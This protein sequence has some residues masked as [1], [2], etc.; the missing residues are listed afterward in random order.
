MSLPTNRMPGDVIKA[1]DIN[2]IAEA[3]NALSDGTTDHSAL[4]NRD[5][6]D[7]HPISAITGLQ[8][9]LNGK[10]N[11][12]HT[13]GAADL[14]GVVKTVNGEAPDSSGDVAVAG[15][16]AGEFELRGTGMPN[17][18]VTATPGTYY[19]DTAG[20]NGAWRWLKT[21]GAGNTG[22]EVVHGDTGRR[23]IVSM[24]PAPWN[25]GMSSLRLHRVGSIVTVTGAPVVIPTDSGLSNIDI[26][27]LPV[28]FRA[29]GY[30]P[31][32][33]A[34]MPNHP[35]ATN[36]AISGNWLYV[37]AGGAGFSSSIAYQF[38]HSLT[39]VTG[40]PWPTVLPGVPA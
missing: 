6:A 31:A 27:A 4:S 7:Q 34:A 19:T 16:G 40:D 35:A 10:A 23:N 9:A 17:G 5:A 12:S 22:W 2:Q 21:S 8:T 33:L 39:F 13:H 11:A 28:G 14:T 24:L 36:F 1:V 18:V 20:T 30:V 15:G 26:G 32:A 3:V 29:V 37:E 38:I 25:Q